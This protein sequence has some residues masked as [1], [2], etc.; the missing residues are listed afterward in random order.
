MKINFYLY[1][2]DPKNVHSIENKLNIYW[3]QRVT[4]IL[5]CDPH[6][7]IIFRKLDIKKHQREY[8]NS[9]FSNGLQ[10]SCMVSK[11]LHY[12][13]L[14]L[15]RHILNEIGE[16]K[17]WEGAVLGSCPTHLN[18][19]KNLIRELVTSLITCSSNMFAYPLIIHI[20]CVVKTKT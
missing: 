10:K 8:T 7:L 1:F 5:F 14:N 20:L 11:W 16:R 6:F 17:T 12:I 15:S 2:Y 19:I 18:S 4:D 3:G 9:L 13:Y